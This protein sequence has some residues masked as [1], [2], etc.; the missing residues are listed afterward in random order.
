MGFI[1]FEYGTEEA[2]KS[3]YDPLRQFIMSDNEILPNQIE[4]KKSTPVFFWNKSGDILE[5]VSL[6]SNVNYNQGAK[7]IKA[8]QLKILIMKKIKKEEQHKYNFVSLSNTTDN[9]II[10]SVS[11]LGKKAGII[12]LKNCRISK[13]SFY[14]I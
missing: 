8:N 12:L 13:G 10:S 1:S 11:I 6:Y 2:L 5:S 9:S 3:K 7:Q 14:I 4:I